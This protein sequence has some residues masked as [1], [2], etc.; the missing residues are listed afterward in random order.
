MKR[1]RLWILGSILALAALVSLVLFS[2]PPPAPFKFLNGRSPVYARGAS[3]H[4]TF[5]GDWDSL[6]QA[7]QAELKA[8]GFQA[9]VMHRGMWTTATFDRQAAQ[10]DIEPWTVEMYK[11][12]SISSRG[13]QGYDK[14]WIT[15]QVVGPR[16]GI[17]GELRELLG[18]R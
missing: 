8:H 4:Y 16:Q 15:I 6:M 13:E 18:R 9:P 17:L 5:K 14:G 3:T 2:P 10:K 1:W 12:Y 11:D 7:A